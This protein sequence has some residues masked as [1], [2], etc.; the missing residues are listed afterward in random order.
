M[1]YHGPVINITLVRMSMPTKPPRTSGL[2]EA[3]LT[4]QHAL[5]RFIARYVKSS[6]DIEDVV[7]EAFLRSYA[8]NLNSDLE[9]PKAFLYQ[10]ARNVALDQLDRASTRLESYLEDLELGDVLIDTV[11]AEEH[12]AQQ[13]Q[14]AIFCKATERLPLQCRRAFI[15]RKV[16]GLSHREIAEQLGISTSTVEKHLAAGILRCRD[17]MTA[18]NESAPAKPRRQQR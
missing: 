3:Y 9:H 1:G 6:H 4:H 11:S 15:L 18:C 8:A 12:A 16:Y 10:T 13:E 14:F 5:G 7:Q 2:L 17:Y